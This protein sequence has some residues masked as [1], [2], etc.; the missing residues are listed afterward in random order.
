MKLPKFTR[1]QFIAGVAATSLFPT[2]PAQAQVGPACFAL[3][4]GVLGCLVILYLLRDPPA[5][6]EL[7]RIA[8]EKSTNGGPWERVMI[9]EVMLLPTDPRLR[10]AFA[11]EIISTNGPTV[12]RVCEVPHTPEFAPNVDKPRTDIVPGMLVYMKSK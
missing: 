3:G 4:I 7:H 5:Q 11:E 12:Y 2:T 1:R 6:P 8:L 9:A 10:A